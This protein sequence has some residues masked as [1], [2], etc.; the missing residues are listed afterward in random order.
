MADRDMWGTVP[1]G[2]RIDGYAP[3]R[4][5]AV[6]GDGRTCA[7]VAFDGSID[8]L[9]LPDID[10]PAAFAR[11]LD[12]D[13]GGCFDL[14]PADPFEAARRYEEGTN[15]LETTFR[16]ASGA[17][18]VVDALTLTDRPELSPLRELTRRVEGLAGT[19]PM[20]WR[21]E[22]RF[23]Y[24]ATEARVERRSGAWFAVG[25]RTALTL[26]TWG[27]G[28]PHPSDGA[29][30]GEFRADEGS[31]ALL[32]LSSAHKEPAILSPRDRIEER[33]A[34]TRRFWTDWSGS[35]SYDGPWR[36]AVVRSALVLKLLVYAPSGAIVAAPTTSLP[37]RLGGG[38]NWDY[39]FTWPR[40]ASFTLEA[41]LRLGYREEGH[42][43]FWWLMHA[44]RITQ[45]RLMTLYRVNGDVHVPEAELSHLAGYR[46]SSPVRL[47]NGAAKQLQL[48]VYGDVLDAIWLY[49][50][51]VGRIDGD[52][53]KEIAAIAD[54]VAKI[55]RQP[56]S[57][58]W[59]VRNEPRHFVQSKG[60]CWVAL[61]RACRLAENGFI[62]DRRE[63]WRREADEIRRFLAERAWDAERQAFVR[64]PD[65]P[66]LDA[67]VL[68]LALLECQ[69]ADR[70]RMSATAD[71][72]RRELGAGPF[73]YRYRGLDGAGGP[74]EEGAF[75]ACS[76][77]LAGALARLGRVDEAH[78]LMDEL[79]AA[80]NDV[81]LYSEEIDPE[82]GE[83]L[84]NFP[85]GLTHLG[86]IT[87][88][89]AVTDA[90]GRR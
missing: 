53:A 47:G 46:G 82:T 7:L 21:L 57:G 90:E 8:W 39:R 85:Q 63:R 2:A 42:A 58:I 86:L 44:S 54:Y 18:R 65:L 38:R 76:F 72:L 68:T 10:S 48:D 34:F 55:W 37:E 11:L 51:T 67:S 75:L 40:D 17:V 87:A 52:T 71:A 31:V 62:P 1:A 36:D 14:A 32:A 15:V 83:F 9:C 78:E 41:L 56:D 43:F 70:D 3:I 6:I 77:W 35:A 5:Y 73:L 64:A 22:P 45:P 59:E 80:A 26:Q 33:L 61:D 24:G 60:M 13:R 12:A 4:D 50:S 88:A 19:V 30:S 81:G 29:L 16:T 69:A 28:E 25:G 74:G 89:V 49:A 84:G 79:V 20:R 27:A 23:G 66:E